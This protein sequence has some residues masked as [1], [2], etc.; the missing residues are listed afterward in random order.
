[1]EL[2]MCPKFAPNS[3]QL[4]EPRSHTV[5]EHA[6]Q[7]FQI[8]T[9]GGTPLACGSEH[10]RIYGTS[11]EAGGNMTSRAALLRGCHMQSILPTD[12][13]SDVREAGFRWKT[14]KNTLNKLVGMSLR[15]T[16]PCR[17]MNFGEVPS[18]RVFSRTWPS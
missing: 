7:R 15:G 16:L 11:L 18:G 3:S 9:P 12:W 4:G 17:S 13:C 14:L 6:C 8:S 5:K 1:M 2:S 10:L